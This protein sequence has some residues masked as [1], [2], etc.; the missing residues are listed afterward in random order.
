MIDSILVSHKK[1][2]YK[3]V[4]CS[5]YFPALSQLVIENKEKHE[6]LNLFVELAADKLN[7]Q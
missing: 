1:E 6:E 3:I 7:Y 4:R 2:K 5:V